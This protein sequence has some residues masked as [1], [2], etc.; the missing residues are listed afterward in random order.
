MGAGSIGAIDEDSK[1]KR[2]KRGESQ[3]HAISEPRSLD[4]SAG[5]RVRTCD[6]LRCCL[7]VAAVTFIIINFLIILYIYDLL[8]SKA[9]ILIYI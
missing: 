6:G 2:K 4:A 9:K 7:T 5:L 3:A 1:L 8:K